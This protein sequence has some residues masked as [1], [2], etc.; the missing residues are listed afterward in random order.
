MN[1]EAFFPRKK[2][3]AAGFHSGHSSDKLF[4]SSVKRCFD[5]A[6]AKYVAIL[7]TALFA[8]FIHRCYVSNVQVWTSI[9]PS[10]VVD[11]VGQ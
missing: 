7:K 2:V 10:I 9:F 11:H 8:G 6:L 3:T 4:C 5:P 1:R